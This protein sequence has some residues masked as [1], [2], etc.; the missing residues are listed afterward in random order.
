[1]LS[2]KKALWA[3]LSLGLTVGFAAASI[4]ARTLAP[5]DEGR[6][7]LNAVT[8]TGAGI[9]LEPGVARNEIGYGQVSITGTATVTMEVRVHSS[10]PWVTA[11]TFTA[12]GMAQAPRCAQMRFNVTSYTS[13]SVSA[14]FSK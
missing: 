4:S 14:W 10:A 7:A 8:T 1:M 13:G 3:G 11:Y 6:L 12:S 5:V 2:N 9:T